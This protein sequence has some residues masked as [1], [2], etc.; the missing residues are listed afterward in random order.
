MFRN[1][2]LKN[3][4]W[5]QPRKDGK[6]PTCYVKHDVR[7][8]GIYAFLKRRG[9]KIRVNNE[10]RYF[11]NFDELDRFLDQLHLSN[12]EDNSEFMQILNRRSTSETL[13]QLPL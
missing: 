13:R 2:L 7:T 8:G 5:A 11:N 9:V 4:F 1:Y 3:D 12:R 6:K 10:E